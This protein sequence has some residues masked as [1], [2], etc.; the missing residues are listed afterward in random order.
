MLAIARYVSAMC[1]EW[2]GGKAET[3]LGKRLMQL[4]RVATNDR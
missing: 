4:N 3:I 1:R 2:E